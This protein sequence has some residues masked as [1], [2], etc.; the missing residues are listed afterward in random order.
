MAFVVNSNLC[1]YTRAPAQV[2]APAHAVLGLTLTP[3]KAWVG[4]AN[5]YGYGY[6]RSD[7][8]GYEYIGMRSH[9][10]NISINKYAT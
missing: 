3:S 1:S 6:V 4:L 10:W 2:D 7:R 5:R 9:A 8:Y